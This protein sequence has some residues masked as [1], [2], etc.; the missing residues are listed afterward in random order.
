MFVLKQ[1]QKAALR[2]FDS[3]ADVFHRVASTFMFLLLQL[4]KP[5]LPFEWSPWIWFRISFSSFADAFHRVA[6]HRIQWLLKFSSNKINFLC[7][8]VHSLVPELVT[9]TSHH[10]MHGL[11]VDCAEHLWHFIKMSQIWWRNLKN[12]MRKGKSNTLTSHRNS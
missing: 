12:R 11:K 6:I 9:L 7:G 5:A 10:Q 3:F 2:C 4:Q 8:T 1:L